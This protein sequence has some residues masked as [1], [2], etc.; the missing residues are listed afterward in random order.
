MKNKFK[1]EYRDLEM[2]VL[3]E[4][5]NKVESSKVFSK[6]ISNC[7]AITVNVFDCEELVIVNDR[8][9]FL[10]NRGYHIGIYAECSLEGLIDLL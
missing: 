3:R 4:L 1:K 8:L 5:R 9:T 7:K 6:H 10:D 2:M